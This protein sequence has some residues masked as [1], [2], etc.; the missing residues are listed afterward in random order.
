MPINDHL[1]VDWC[2]VRSSRRCCRNLIL[3]SL[4]LLIA[5]LVSFQEVNGQVTEPV[6]YLKKLPGVIIA[7]LSA[8]PTDATLPEGRPAF[9]LGLTA[10]IVG[11]L[12]VDKEVRNSIQPATEVT[13]K[14]LI[15]PFRL[16]R[17]DLAIGLHA[18]AF[19]LLGMG[20][21]TGKEGLTRWGGAFTETIILLDVIVFPVKVITGRSRPG[22]G[23]ALDFSMPGSIYD[24]FPSGH[25]AY[26][27][28]LASLLSRS[29][30]PAWSKTLFWAGASG[31]ALQRI[32]SDQHWTSDVVVGALLGLWAGHRVARR[33]WGVS[34]GSSGNP[35]KSTSVG[36]GQMDSSSL[37][38]FPS[39]RR[40][41]VSLKASFIFKSN[42]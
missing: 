4:G 42:H 32:F 21:I 23:S 28:G 13:R 14:Y 6:S 7:D 20:W 18:G 2:T 19:G 5:V 34:P 16:N 41:C 31:V 37:I 24:A 26:S 36:S 11:P 27:F 1:I 8:L 22:N 29:P 39:F 38:I 15:R 30:A 12:F 40:N 3:V 25:T 9:L 35:G 33:Y 17:M 10:A